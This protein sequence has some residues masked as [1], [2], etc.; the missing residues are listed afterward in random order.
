MKN[1]TENIDKAPAGIRLLD[2]DRG[3]KA[4]ETLF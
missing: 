1:A 3:E 4:N 2:I